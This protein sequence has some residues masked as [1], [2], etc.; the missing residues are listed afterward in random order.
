MR[1]ALTA[2]QRFSTYIILQQTRP[3]SNHSQCKT[4]YFH[5]EFDEHRI[6]SIKIAERVEVVAKAK[7]GTQPAARPDHL[8]RRTA[9]PRPPATST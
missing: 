9:V 7:L 5:I 8:P 2:K 4:S 3:K 6:F 1:D